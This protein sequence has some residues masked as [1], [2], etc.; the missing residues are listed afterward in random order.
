MPLTTYT[1]EKLDRL[2][3]IFFEKI[4]RKERIKR[5]LDKL[6][7]E[8]LAYIKPKVNAWLEQTNKQII[9]DLTKKFI[10]KRATAPEIVATLTDWEEIEDNGKKIFKPAVINIMAKSGDKAL[11][12]AGVEASFDVL[13]VESVA[14][15]EKICSTL[16][17]EVTDETK[18][19]ISGIIKIGIKDGKSMGQVAKEIRPLVGL[20]T[21]QT[22]A[23]VHYNERL[24]ENRPEWS[25]KQINNSVAAYE[26]KMHRMRAD[27]IARTETARA[28][29]EGTLQGYGQSGV[30]KR[31]EWVV[32][33]DCCSDCASMSGKTFTL[34]EA[35][36]MQ[37]RHPKCRCCWVVA[38]P[39]AEKKPKIP[40]RPEKASDK[41]TAEYKDKI[42]EQRKLT[43]E[44]ALYRKKLGNAYYREKNFVDVKKYERLM[45]ETSAKRR[46]S[47]NQMKMGMR[48]DLYVDKALRPD[49]R[50]DIMF[51]GIGPEQERK[52]L[53]A[54]NECEKFLNKD[55][56]GR[57]ELLVK[58]ADSRA[59]YDM[60]QGICLGRSGPYQ[61]AGVVNKTV[62]HEMGHYLEDASGKVH[63]EI[64]EFYHKRTKGCPLEWLGSGYGKDELTRK[65]KFIDAY[66]GKD[67]RGQASEILSMGLQ[68][69]YNDPYKLALKDPEYFN[70]IYKLVRGAL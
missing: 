41:L 64:M 20:T 53:K 16:V 45:K 54:V 57:Y 18:K 33:A 70:F 68:Y 27:T 52:I 36:G 29:S 61:S 17:R 39:R 69:F 59:F 5:K 23:V 49:F 66:M 14:I 67:Y 38:I 19:A 44:I 32:S 34:N 9:K 65:D 15:T 1:V 47:I 56:V 42:E 26:R 60:R 8:N 22:M 25:I 12:I 24:I 31:V 62:I 51:P 50:P 30:V 58:K 4:G 63:R 43:S 7:E 10:K 28:Q 2:L 3:D 46:Y 35:S 40:G 55:M 21:K 13:R 37:P 6:F 11:E 48:K